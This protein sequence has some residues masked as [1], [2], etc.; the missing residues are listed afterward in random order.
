MFAGF[1]GK[2]NTKTNTM[3]TKSNTSTTT[4]TPTTKTTTTTIT[5]TTTAAATTAASCYDCCEGEV[6]KSYSGLDA[7]CPCVSGPRQT[8]HVGVPLR[9]PRG[10][11]ADSFQCSLKGC[12]KA[13]L[14]VS[15][16]CFFRLVWKFPKG[17]GLLT[18]FGKSAMQ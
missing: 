2:A 5:A 8:P 4:T 15:F 9:V 18:Y 11:Y 6:A 10:C 12:V 17:S 14:R 1:S 3:N 16:S 7:G 13:S